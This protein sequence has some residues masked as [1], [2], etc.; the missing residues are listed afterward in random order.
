MGN[1]K[2]NQVLQHNI[3][4]MVHLANDLS[5]KIQYGYP[6]LVAPFLI[7]DRQKFKRKHYLSRCQ[8]TYFLPLRNLIKSNLFKIVNKPFKHCKKLFQLVLNATQILK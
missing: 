6:I 1:I 3:S 2:F 7:P 8:E 5:S 4:E